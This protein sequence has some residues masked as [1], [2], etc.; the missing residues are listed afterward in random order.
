MGDGESVVVII[1]TSYSKAKLGKMFFVC[2][3]VCMFSE[4]ARASGWVC[5]GE[6]GLGIENSMGDPFE[7][8]PNHW[9]KNEAE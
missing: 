8:P 4:C 1:S 6:G 7:P 5:R 3:V 9:I 2:G